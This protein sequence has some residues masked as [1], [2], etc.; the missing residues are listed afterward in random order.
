MCGLSFFRLGLVLYICRANVCEAEAGLHLQASM[1][2]S[3][4]LLER[5]CKYSRWHFMLWSQTLHAGTP[6]S[7]ARGRTEYLSY[8]VQHVA[9]PQS[10]SSA[11]LNDILMTEF[12]SDF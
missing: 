6:V 5:K 9:Q 4:E 2:D 3:N 10:G 7:S 8:H 1:G 11:Q 12:T